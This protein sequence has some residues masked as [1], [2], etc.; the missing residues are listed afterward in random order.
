[1]CLLVAQVA[2]AQAV[3]PRTRA[4]VLLQEARW[5]EAES[6]FYLQSERAPRDP[7]ARAALGKFLAMKGAIRPGIVL[8]EEARQF[9]LN[10]Q[11][12]RDL[13][14]PLRVILEWRTAA[15]DLK[16]D[17]TV[18]IR[19]SS[20][21]TVLFRIAFPRAGDAPRVSKDVG[22]VSENV[23]HDVVDRQVGLDSLSA[24]GSPI[25]VEVFEGLIPSVDVRDRTA[26]LHANPRSALSA[27]GRRYPV[28]RTSRGVWVLVGE[29]RAVR[30]AQ[31]LRELDADWWQ[32]DLLNGLLVTR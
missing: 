1:M 2:H 20:D 19:P 8:I 11:L 12:A 3:L 7:A 27:T 21:S 5:T 9:G 23:W 30:L 17:S 25:G 31:A 15:R 18:A 24:R 26:T 13:T 16:A 10:P 14:A 29:M 6:M 22:A 28:L 4:D 32:L